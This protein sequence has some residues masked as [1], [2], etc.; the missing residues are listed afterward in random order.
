[1]RARPPSLNDLSG[2]DASFSSPGGLDTLSGSIT[3]DTTGDTVVGTDPA[4]GTITLAGPIYAGVYSVGNYAYSSSTDILVQGLDADIDFDVFLN[5]YLASAPSDAPDSVTEVVLQNPFGSSYS[6]TQ[7]AG[8]INPE[9][10]QTTL[11][12]PASLALIVP[13]LVGL[14]MLRRKADGSEAAF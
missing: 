11:P 10:T 2:V 13:A 4:S 3:L 6:T 1:M 12:E 9:T 8:T 7:V 14:G 5:I